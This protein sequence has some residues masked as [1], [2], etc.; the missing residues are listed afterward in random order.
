MS[1]PAALRWVT[2]A[3]PGIRRLGTPQ[4]FRYRD[5]AGRAVRD[6][7]T[8]A[9]IRALAIPP[10]YGEVWICATA[11]GHIQAT[12]RD[13]RGRKQYRYHE[14]WQQQRSELKYGQLRAFGEALP[15]IR[16]RLTRRLAEGE[17]TREAVLA[18]VVRLL[19]RTQARIGNREYARDNGSYGLT[20]LRTRH[21]ASLSR[22]GL[23]LAFDGKSGVRHE[24]TLSDRRVARV[25]RRCAELPG[26]PLFQYMDADGAV[27]G[28]TSTDVNAW[29]SEAAG[30]DA[31][32]KLF[33]TWHGSVA[34]LELLLGS[35]AAERQP[36]TAIIKQVATRL[37]NTPAV[38]RKAYIHPAVLALADDLAPPE[39]RERVE[40]AAWYRRPRRVA[41]L[42]LAERRFLA[43]L[44][45]GKT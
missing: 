4:R 16:A 19:D 35:L 33:R 38:C 30:F 36:L 1:Q 31:T 40:R 20:T 12:A 21:L 5:A 45:R 34:A 25:V 6:D 15:R 29:L 42:S 37:G 18:A 27:R 26:Q 11:D 17:A 2:D 22:G 14:H 39:G 13:A 7:A 32:A 23:R 43:L 44:G 9:R 28:I 24:L 3:E 10:A 41:G 8:L